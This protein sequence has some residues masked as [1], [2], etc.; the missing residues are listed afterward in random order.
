M[1]EDQMTIKISLAILLIAFAGLQL[2]RWLDDRRAD[3]AW[4][5]MAR[6]PDTSPSRFDPS[7]VDRLP[8]PARRFFRFAIKPGAALTTVAE[9]RMGGELG[10]GTKEEPNYMPMRAHQILTPP[11]GFVWKLSA[12]RGAMRVSGSDGFDGARS[13]VRF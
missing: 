10:L 5:D 2:W 3:K 8:E 9:I 4:R 12:G 7:M 6:A 1:A 11:G 13:W